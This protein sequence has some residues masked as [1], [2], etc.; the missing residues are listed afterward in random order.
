MADRRTHGTGERA[1]EAQ[2]PDGEVSPLPQTQSVCGDKGGSVWFKAM[3]LGMTLALKCDKM[4]LQAD[5]F[6]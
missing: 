6:V 3:T 1:P 4:N 5:W 2:V